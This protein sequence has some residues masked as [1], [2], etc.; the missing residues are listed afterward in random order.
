[1]SNGW[2]K[3]KAMGE[4]TG[5]IVTRNIDFP[6]TLQATNSKNPNAPVF[7]VMAK[8][9][10]GTAFKVGVA[11]EKR[12]KEKTDEQGVITGGDVFYSISID[13]PSLPA[14]LYVTAFGAKD[15][16]GE[17]DIFWQRPRAKEA[18]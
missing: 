4:W 14:P 5:H 16:P 8:S 13:D 7:E 9:K 18:A 1:M 6:F 17:F 2:I 10:L 15:R 3:Q 12:T 11:F